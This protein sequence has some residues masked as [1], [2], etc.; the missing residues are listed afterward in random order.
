ML[1]RLS[2]RAFD[3]EVS[4]AR[5]EIRSACLAAA[6]QSGKGGDQAVRIVGRYRGDALAEALR[7]EK[8]ATQFHHLAGVASTGK[9]PLLDVPISEIYRKRVLSVA[10]TL[11]NTLNQLVGERRPGVGMKG[12]AARE[13]YRDS[14]LARDLGD[15]DLWVQDPSNA[16]LTWSNCLNHQ[17]WFNSREYPWLKWAADGQIYGQVNLR[18]HRPDGSHDSSR[19]DIDVHFGGYSVRHCGRMPRL[20]R[21]IRSN[22]FG[23]RFVSPDDC[24][25]QMIINAA[26]DHRIT[27]KDLLD[28]VVLSRV[29]EDPAA[30][31]EQIVVLGLGGFFNRMRKQ[32]TAHGILIS[33][34]GF[35]RISLEKPAPS[36][37]LVKTR[38]TIVTAAHAWR[39]SPSG[40]KNQ[41]SASATRYYAKRLA[42]HAP[43]RQ[44]FRP[45]LDPTACIRL[46]PLGVDYETPPSKLPL[47]RP[48][49]VDDGVDLVVSWMGYR[50]APTI[51]YDIA[52]GHLAEHRDDPRNH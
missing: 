42:L 28:V 2:T 43:R 17:Y 47:F 14:G 49:T 15:L 30:T 16:T 10:A 22:E 11:D 33:I 51:F 8:V 38:R 27:S 31:A 35:D 50:F 45:I 26:G 41:A 4:A 24:L 9:L 1:D 20:M 32:L 7:L 34:Q 39:V 25:L 19:P 6:G 3:L 52:D 40:R 44:P 46:I 21:E 29:L 37:S 13:Y 18:P 36:Q 23:Q 12:L 48:C 5:N